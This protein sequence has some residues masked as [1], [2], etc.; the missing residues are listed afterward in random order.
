M[1]KIE[2]KLDSGV[3]LIECGDDGGAVT[4]QGFKTD[5]A[6]DEE[7]VAWNASVDAIESLLLAMA[8]EGIDLDTPAMRTALQTTLEAMSN[9]V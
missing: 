3:F 8:M 5:H 2:L 7:D 6:M 4:S 1:Q 9:H